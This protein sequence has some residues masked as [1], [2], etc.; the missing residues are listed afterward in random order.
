MLPSRIKLGTTTTNQGTSQSVNF[1][2]FI[3]G[4]CRIV[5]HAGPALFIVVEQ[6][7][8]RSIQAGTDVVLRHLNREERITDDILDRFFLLTNQAQERSMIVG[9]E[10]H[11]AARPYHSFDFRPDFLDIFTSGKRLV[12]FWAELSQLLFEDFNNLVKW[13]LG[14]HAN[15]LDGDACDI[16]RIGSLSSQSRSVVKKAAADN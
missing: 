10:E 2:K 4:E 7:S 14:H 9:R 6:H 16:H 1:V 15:V 5:L 8:Q 11:E 12:S 13:L 3:M